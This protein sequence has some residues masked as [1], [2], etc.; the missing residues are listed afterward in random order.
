MR[1][2]VLA[3]F[4]GLMTMVSVA[5]KKELKAAEKAL[6]TQ[7]YASAL[8][9]IDA[10]KALNA[11]SDS[12]LST[13][14]HFLKGQAFVGKKEYKVAAEAF[15][16]VLDI[17][18]EAKK[19]KYTKKAGGELNKLISEVSNRAI[20]LYGKKDYKKASKDFYLTYVLSP[21]DTSFLY[22]AAISASIAKEL[23]NSL[24]YYKELIKVGYE[25]AVISYAATS[26]ETGEEVVFGNKVMRDFAVKAK[27]HNNPVV[28]KTKSKKGTIIKEMAIILSQQGRV[29]EAVVAI[30]KARKTDPTNLNLLLMEADFYIKLGK[31]EEFGQ[32]MKE[33]V[34]KDPTNPNLYFNL[35]VVTYNQERTEEAKKYYLKAIE[36][37]SDYVDAYMNLAILILDK[38]VKIVEEM[39]KNLSNFKKYD[40]LELQQKEV[41]KEALP[42]L[43]K[44]H[45]LNKNLDTIRTLLN[46]YENLEMEEKAKEFR[47]LYKAMRA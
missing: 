26:V 15:N 10:A 6:K 41:Y 28:K 43:E 24:E 1:K 40:E 4:L 33:A 44:A 27:S 29:D 11:D 38:D 37:K 42:Y 45:S 17:E 20:D 21:T 13:K 23:D 32:L 36:L 47:A 22:N 34:V 39:N 3:L 18:K 5:Q 2:Q 35:G 8:T 31:M 9:A 14:F 16:K 19:F 7:D 46:I 25:G 30:K 12:K